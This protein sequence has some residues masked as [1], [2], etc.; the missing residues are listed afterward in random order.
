MTRR[1]KLPNSSISVIWEG[2]F[3]FRKAQKFDEN[4]QLILKQ[5]K[6]D[7]KATKYYEKSDLPKEF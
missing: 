6:V 3:R 2:L 5:S 7:I 4:L 1:E